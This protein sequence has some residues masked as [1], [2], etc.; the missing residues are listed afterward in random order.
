MALPSQSA[1]G[2]G[3]RSHM[4][5][6]RRFARLPIMLGAGSAVAGGSWLLIQSMGGDPRE[7]GASPLSNEASAPDPASNESMQAGMGAFGQPRTP[8]A[9]N[10]AA[11]SA[12]GASSPRYTAAQQRERQAQL[13][14]AGDRLRGAGGSVPA[15]PEAPGNIAHTS[16]AASARANDATNQPIPAAPS[17]EQRTPATA[18]AAADQLSRGLELLDSDPLAA[19][20]TLTAALHSAALP[21]EDE[22][23]IRM[24]LTHLS[25]R[26]IFG[27]VVHPQDAFARTHKVASGESLGKIAKDLDIHV[28]W[29]FLLRIN[30]MKDARSLRAGQ[31]L[32]VI[33][34]PFH[35]VIDKSDYRLDLYLGEGEDRVFVRSFR[36]GL[37][38]YDSTPA[39]MFRV[40]VKAENPTWVNPRDPREKYSA[41]DPNNP[42]GDHWLAL[43]GV[44]E[45]TRD[46]TGY[47][48]HGTI[49]P[50][51]IGGQ[52]SMGC[53]RMLPEDVKLIFEV[54]MTDV[55]MVE[56]RN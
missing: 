36:V 51:S 5:R 40:G 46:F 22:E 4:F 23:N 17:A 1:R 42:I 33:T 38:E 11:E 27:R 52:Q 30:G 37:G 10:G 41:D 19:R 25:E 48:I 50:Q 2:D 20:R 54:L 47:G 39:G 29:R 28:D 49:E 26:L 21:R 24:A 3:R 34:G 35:A 7:A 15:T 55:S 16:D 14:Q 31:D 18:A 45:V 13:S 32:K 44:D 12:A 9:G 8:P 43:I 6:R 56:I 53:V